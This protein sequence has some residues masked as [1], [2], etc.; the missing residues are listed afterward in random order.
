MTD[1]N[2]GSDSTCVAAVVQ[3]VSGQ[4]ISANLAAAESQV[5][6][7]ASQ[8]AR[9]IVLPEN[10]LVFDSEA[11]IS[12]AQ[13]EARNGEQI[14]KRLA[15]LSRAEGIYLVAGS[16]PVAKTTLHQPEDDRRALSASLVYGPEGG[17]L[18]EYHK[19]HLFDVEVSGDSQ[20]YMESDYFRE[21]EAPQTVELPWGLLG[22]SICYD[23]RFPELYRAY[24][25]S[26]CTML[27][28]PSA[29]T[30]KTGEAHWDV[31]LRARA[32]ENQCFV[33]APNQ[34]GQHENGRHTFGHSQI[35]DPWGRVLAM[36]ESG[37]GIAIAELDFKELAQI[38]RR[39]PVEQHRR[40]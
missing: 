36:V 7:A 16:L 26:G 38:R 24:A 12:L 10:F 11:A 8:G 40:L 20:R 31:L 27:T 4:D 14:R 21:G 28:V 17:L 2:S 34:G 23:L 33:F 1:D 18:A 35:V 30:A 5:R 6:A 3:M 22:L 9:L 25:R 15:D 19:M 13:S 29:F 37:P 39:M 32:I